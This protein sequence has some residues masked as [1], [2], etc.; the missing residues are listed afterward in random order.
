MEI[1]FSSPVGAVVVHE[2]NDRALNSHLRQPAIERDDELEES[3]AVHPPSGLD[4][5]DTLRERFSV[6]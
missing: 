5:H 1:N 2:Q 3:F 6:D 4:P